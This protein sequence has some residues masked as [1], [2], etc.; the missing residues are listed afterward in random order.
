MA[1]MSKVNKQFTVLFILTISLILITL[2]F[3]NQSKAQGE[4]LVDFTPFMVLLIILI[5]IIVGVFI[6]ISDARKGKYPKQ[7]VVEQKSVKDGGFYG[8]LYRTFTKPKF[9]V[10]LLIVLYLY[11]PIRVV[12][13][14]GFGVGLILSSFATGLLVVLFAGFGLFQY[15]LLIRYEES[16]I[17]IIAAIAYWP[18]I[19]RSIYLILMGRLTQK[20]TVILGIIIFLLLVLG[21]HGCVSQAPGIG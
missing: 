6:K 2:F 10:I 11:L 3:G 13:D 8:F 1:N 21:F 19:L 5:S 14:G 12:I 18:F 17:T 16:S 4:V 15:P 7:K 20:K 9:W